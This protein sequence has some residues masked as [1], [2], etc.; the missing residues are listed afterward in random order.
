MLEA[1]KC[2]ALDMYQLGLTEIFFRADTLALMENERARRPDH[3][4][5]VIQCESYVLSPQVS[6]GT[7]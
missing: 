1:S 2:Q 6:E 4:A 5:T 7:R 3:C